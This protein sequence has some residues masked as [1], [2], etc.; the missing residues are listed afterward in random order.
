MYAGGKNEEKK[1]LRALMHTRSYGDLCVYKVLLIIRL[2]VEH[3]FPV[4]G[5]GNAPSANLVGKARVNGSGVYLS[6]PRF[7]NSWKRGKVSPRVT[8]RDVY[9][10]MRKIRLVSRYRILRRGL[11]NGTRAI[12]DLQVLQIMR[13]RNIVFAM[14]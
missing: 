13:T 1:K 8:H 9:L 3:C 5:G 4:R 6:S 11:F 10:P 14:K 12:Q 7:R 2:Q